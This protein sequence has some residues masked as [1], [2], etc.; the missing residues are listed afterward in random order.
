MTRDEAL[1]V[2][3][4]TEPLSPVKLRLAY[5]RAAFHAHPDRGGDLGEMKRVNEAHDVLRG[6]DAAPAPA[7]APEARGGRPRR[8]PW[9]EVYDWGPGAVPRWRNYDVPLGGSDPNDYTGQLFICT[10]CRSVYRGETFASKCGCG[11]D[12]RRF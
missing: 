5:R 9:S 10:R 1:R 7:P 4:L 8:R 3:S 2:L 12:V 11:G 6:R